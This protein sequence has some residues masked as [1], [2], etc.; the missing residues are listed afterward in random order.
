MHHHLL[1]L[2]LMKGKLAA[3][4]LQRLAEA[5]HVAVAENA[6]DAGNQALLEAVALAPLRLEIEHDGLGHGEFD[7][8]TL[9]V[10]PGSFIADLLP[11]DRLTLEL[12]VRSLTSPAVPSTVTR[13]EVRRGAWSFRLL[14]GRISWVYLRGDPTNFPGRISRRSFRGGLSLDELGPIGYL[15]EDPVQLRDELAKRQLRLV[16]GFI[17]ELLHDPAER[18]TS[19]RSPTAPAGSSPRSRPSVCPHR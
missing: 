5:D 16:A 2:G 17:F 19:E 1:V 10:A 14:M 18:P 9:S 12:F 3:I 4:F 13:R 7:G 11:C 8:Q 15:P 6:E